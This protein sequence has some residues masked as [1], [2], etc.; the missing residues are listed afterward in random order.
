MNL[1]SSSTEINNLI[2]NNYKKLGW[3]LKI[4]NTN[5]ISVFKSK[6]HLN[7][8]HKFIFKPA[9]FEQIA[10]FLDLNF[11]NEN[12]SNVCFANDKDL[13]SEFKGNFSAE[14]VL[15]CLYAVLHLENEN[16]LMHANSVSTLFQKNNTTEIQNT[17]WKLVE[18]GDKARNNKI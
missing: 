14:D 6:R 2:Q 11:E 1:E 18:V 12:A 15:N 3:C 10:K 13:R 16:S 7:T 17:F 8:N 5:Q 9:F 4:L